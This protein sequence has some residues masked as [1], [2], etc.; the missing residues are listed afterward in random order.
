[1]PFTR[2]AAL[3][4]G[5]IAM[6]AQIVLLRAFMAIFWGNELL[7]GFL[8]AIWMAFSA[9]GSWF[10]NRLQPAPATAL[11]LAFRLQGIALLCGVLALLLLPGARSVLHLSAAEYLAIPHLLELAFVTV[12][13]VAVP[14]GLAFALLAGAAAGESDN[15]AALVYLRDAA[16]S[17]AAS[18]LFTFLLVHWLSPVQT[19]LIAGLV[20]NIMAAWHSG[21]RL[22]PALWAVG[23]GALFLL[24][25]GVEQQRAA[26]WWR[27]FAPGMMLRERATSPHGELA[28]VNWGGAPA[29]FSNGVLQTAL[30]NLIDS[31]AQAALLLSQP[32]PAPRRILL[33]GGGAGGLAPELARPPD[34]QVT[35]IE[36][37]RRAFE[38]ALAAW[39]DSLRSR[40][41]NPRLTVR[42]TD[43]RHFLQRSSERYDLLVINA[44]R[45]AGAQ[46][47]RYYTEEF[48]SLAKNRLAPAGI[49][50]LLNVPCG[51]NYLGTELL[52]LN[53]ALH[54]ALQ[55]T[56]ERV[57]VIPGDEA[58]YLAGAR[59]VVTADPNQLESRLAAQGPGFDYFFPPMFATWLPAARMAAL[60][61]QLA[62]ASAWRNRDFHPIAYWSD[63]ML[64]Q[65]SVRGSSALLIALERIG[66]S[67]IALIW[68]LLLATAALAAWRHA[69]RG[70]RGSGRQ[71][72]HP[73]IPLLLLA[74][75]LLGMAATAFDVL[76]ILALQSLFGTLYEAISLALAAFMAGLA[77]GGW[78]ALRARPRHRAALAALLLALIALAALLL[79]PFF[80]LLA[81]H[82]ITLLFYLG[83]LGVSGLVGALFPLLA[84]LHAALAGPGRWG[85]INGADLA[86]GATAALLIG[87]FWVPLFGFAHSL[88]LLALAHLAV[89]AALLAA[90]RPQFREVC[91]VQTRYDPDRYGEPDIRE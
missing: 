41:H 61:A 58:I 85:T 9:L 37:D 47:N 36:A 6:L 35:D 45:P 48:F 87:G 17:V 19:L 2:P 5:V 78:L 76:F 33:I 71:G 32:L 88:S 67:R 83:L 42:H 11:T 73:L 62:S 59:G 26:A 3:L 82:P 8:L 7:V 84:G 18:L 44:G 52:R 34:V 15:P 56:F 70:G 39:P 14:L 77:G 51:E 60:E 68:A 57:I 91:D 81:R 22:G 66:Y 49:L 30:P 86:G 29:L 24:A 64:W 55:R 74:A 63:L 40:W 69:R 25:P 53:R 72:S 79:T 21:R 54:A 43:G 50:A 4:L 90:A 12:V 46:A 75:F 27:S 20:L 65:K 10:G 13:P 89:A 28:V 16:G 38:M 23:L 1:M 31:Q 80:T